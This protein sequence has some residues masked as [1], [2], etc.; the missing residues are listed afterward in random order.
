M[1]YKS[2]FLV[3][4]SLLFMCTP[5]FAGIPIAQDK[6]ET[7]S[8]RKKKVTK[9]TEKKLEDKNPNIN[10]MLSFIFGLSGLL[11]FPPLGAAA[12][13]LGIISLNKKEPETWMPIVGIVLG[14]LAVLLTIAVL[15][16]FLLVLG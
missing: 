11:L 2:L 13:I 5:S 15:L 16:F 9:K 12:V 10:G 3:V 1:T 14:S 6:T 8:N 7:I 4:F